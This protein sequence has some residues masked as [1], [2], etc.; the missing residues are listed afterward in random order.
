M[1]KIN[2]VMQVKNMML[3]TIDFKQLKTWKMKFY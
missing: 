3:K 2:L 1:M